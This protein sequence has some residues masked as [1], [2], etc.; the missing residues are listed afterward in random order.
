LKPSAW[1]RHPKPLAILLFA[2]LCAHGAAAEVRVQARGSEVQVETH[3]ATVAE[4]LAALGAS[5][6][7]H[8]RGSTG[9]RPITATFQGPLRRVVA[10]VLEGYNYVIQARGN[11]LDVIVVSTQSPNAVPPP[12]IAPPTVP[13]RRQRDD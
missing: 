5:F 6:A 12:P 7:V 2:A 4:I 9:S 3:D 13:S 1:V 8:Y 11:G 10:R